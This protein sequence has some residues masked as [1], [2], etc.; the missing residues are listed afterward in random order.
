MALA[1]EDGISISTLAA[2]LEVSKAT[3]TPLL[4]RLET[5]GLLRREVRKDNEREKIISLTEDG[6]NIWTKNSD[7][8][9][10]VFAQTG[11]TQAEAKQIIKLCSKIAR[12]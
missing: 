11:L 5:K 1:E 9:L 6:R 4:R 3:M 7:I 10:D 8:S 12:I 2:R